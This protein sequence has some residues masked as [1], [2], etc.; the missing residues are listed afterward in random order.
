MTK[1]PECSESVSGWAERL[2]WSGL[3]DVNVCALFLHWILAETR[4]AELEVM[5]MCLS[6]Q[7][8]AV[9]RRKVRESLLVSEPTEPGYASIHSA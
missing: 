2:I 8:W 9:P 3:S 6:V 4:R 7:G 1:K 5:T